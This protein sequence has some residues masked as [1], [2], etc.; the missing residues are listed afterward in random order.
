VLIPNAGDLRER[1]ARRAILVR[2]CTSFGLRGTVRVGVP[3]E[4]G[5][6]RLARALA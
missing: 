6:A 3:D 1:L 5:L 2:D 4:A